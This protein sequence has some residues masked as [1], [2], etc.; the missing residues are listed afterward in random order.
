M[1]SGRQ[2]PRAVRPVYQP[3]QRRPAPGGERGDERLERGRLDLAA[4]RGEARAQLAQRRHARGGEERKR[5]A[6]DVVRAI[7]RRRRGGG[8]GAQLAVRQPQRREVSLLVQAR[9]LVRARRQVSWRASGRGDG[10]AATA[11]AAAAGRRRQALIAARAPAACSSLK[12]LLAAFGRAPGSRALSPTPNF[13]Q[14]GSLASEGALL[15]Q[16]AVFAIALRLWDPD[17]SGFALCVMARRLPLL[18]RPS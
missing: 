9:R 11:V 16:T 2:A 3:L 15:A 5:A 14:L 10:I 17:R 8:H 4:K 18:L 1:P 6:G 12:P 7:R 13:V